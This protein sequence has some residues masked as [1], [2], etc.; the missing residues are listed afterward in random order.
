MPEVMTSEQVGKAMRKARAVVEFHRCFAETYNVDRL[1]TERLRAEAAQ[2]TLR[3]CA[4]VE[5][6]RAQLA[7][8]V[9]RHSGVE[10]SLIWTQGEAERLRADLVAAREDVRALVRVLQAVPN[11][12]DYDSHYG[13]ALAR[14]DVQRIMEEQQVIF[15]NRPV[16]ASTITGVISDATT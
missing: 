13:N 8:A 9:E 16:E 6:L 1:T 3:L 2:E 10:R 14:P 7:E 12:Q 11:Y 15:P 5:V 4:T